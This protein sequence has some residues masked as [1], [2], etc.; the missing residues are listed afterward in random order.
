[1]KQDTWCTTKLS[2]LFI[3]LINRHEKCKKHWKHVSGM[4]QTKLRE[5]KILDLL[6]ILI[7][8]CINHHNRLALFLNRSSH[9]PPKH[10]G[11]LIFWTI[12]RQIQDKFKTN[13]TISRHI[14]NYVRFLLEQY[15][16][17]LPTMN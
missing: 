5:K 14:R 4:K 2:L 7:N 12:L 9:P 3:L 11:T 1:M 15:F 8:S 6:F 16:I 10:Q 17:G 13:S